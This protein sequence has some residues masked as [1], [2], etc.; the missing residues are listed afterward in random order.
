M[1]NNKKLNKRCI[2]TSG[3]DKFFSIISSYDDECL[4]YITI[5]SL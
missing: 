4:N 1:Y 5:L 3:K 2:K